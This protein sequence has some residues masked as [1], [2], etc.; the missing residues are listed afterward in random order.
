MPKELLYSKQIHASH[1]VGCDGVF[2]CVCVSKI[3]SDWGF[4]FEY[5][6]ETCGDTVSFYQTREVLTTHSTAFHR[7]KKIIA[8]ILDS[9]A[10][11]EVFTKDG[12]FVQEWFTL[13]DYQ[14]LNSQGGAFETL[15]SE[16]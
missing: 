6:C 8:S 13:D 3:V 11:G 10:F 2:E 14:W 7:Q 1:Q 9:P 5:A 15:D 12:G 4:L 16:L